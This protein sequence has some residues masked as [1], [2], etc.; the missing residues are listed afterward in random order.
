MECCS[1]EEIKRKNLLPYAQNQVR[2]YHDIINLVNDTNVR[3]IKDFEIEYG[4]YETVSQGNRI[5]R[6][7]YVANLISEL[8]KDSPVEY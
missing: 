4:D 7:T 3:N 2:F 5:D 6:D 1:A 8:K